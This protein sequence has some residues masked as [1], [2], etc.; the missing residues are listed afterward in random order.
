[1]SL[2]APLQIQADRHDERSIIGNLYNLLLQL[3]NQNVLILWLIYRPML[4]KDVFVAK[5]SLPQQSHLPKRISDMQMDQVGFKEVLF[6][7]FQ[8]ILVHP[9]HFQLAHGIDFRRTDVDLHMCMMLSLN[10]LDLKGF[11]HILAI[12]D[13]EDD[14]MAI[15]GQCVNH[16]DAEV[17]QS[18][19][20][21]GGEP[22]Q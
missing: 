12:A 8:A 4:C 5:E 18:G 2:H 17:A 16:A 15:L 3:P 20:V 19:V 14:G 7:V 21:G 11:R 10:L 6:D 9:Q 13:G 22:T 1:M